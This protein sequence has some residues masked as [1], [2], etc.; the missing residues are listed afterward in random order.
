[1]CA[2]SRYLKGLV[3]NGVRFTFQLNESWKINT[4]IRTIFVVNYLA[5]INYL[6]Q[7]LT[8]SQMQELLLSTFDY[9]LSNFPCALMNE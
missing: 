8:H 5:D 7:L 2:Q 3:L 9:L 4:D 6:L 1:M